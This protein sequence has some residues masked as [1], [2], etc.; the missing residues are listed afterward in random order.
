[1]CKFASFVLTKE[2]VYWLPKDES[3]ENIIKEFKLV[4]LF[5]GKP[6]IVRVEITPNKETIGELDTWQFKID[7]DILPDWYDQ[8]TDELRT[9]AALRSKIGPDIIG[10]L[11]KVQAFIDSLKTYKW[12]TPDGKPLKSWKLTTGNTWAA[13]RAA[14]RAAAG[15][16]ARDAAWAAARAA[17]GDAAR[18]AARAAAWDAAWA[19]AGDAAGD[20]ARAAIAIL[21]AGYIHKR[22]TRHLLARMRVWEKG[23]ACLCDVNGTLYVYAEG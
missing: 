3:H 21:A 7:Q 19:A 1:M 15:D 13:A 9:R 14:A 5:G 18:A 16:A 2:N 20:A 23:Y 10:R 12:L 11:K 8:D 22:H 6:Q 4:E 17:A